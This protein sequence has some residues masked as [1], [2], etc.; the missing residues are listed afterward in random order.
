MRGYFYYNSFAGNHFDISTWVAIIA[1]FAA[2]A[3]AVA[4]FWQANGLKLSIKAETL[5]KFIDRFESQNFKAARK[6]ATLA[7][8]TMLKDKNPGIDVDDVLDFFEDVSFMVEKQALDEEM[9]WHA[10]YHW[11][12][13]YYQASATYINERRQEEPTVWKYFICLYP[14]LNALERSNSFGQY[15]EILD[16]AELKKQL[17]DELN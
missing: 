17:E 1:A 5:L 8:H 15:K 6:T 11:M 2:I 16:D 4:A 9:V 3:A 14:R 12:R 7:C 13:L 10:F